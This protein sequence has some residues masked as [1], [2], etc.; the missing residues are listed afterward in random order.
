[1]LGNSSE[2]GFQDLGELRKIQ[3]FKND[4]TNSDSPA[5]FYDYFK[6]ENYLNFSNIAETISDLSGPCPSALQL[7]RTGLECLPCDLQW[8]HTPFALRWK[9]PEWIPKA[10]CFF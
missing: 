7:T 6:K 3:S 10:L 9:Y 5:P 1:M 4:R 8:I 2:R